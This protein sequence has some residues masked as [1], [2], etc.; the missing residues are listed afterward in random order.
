[1]EL[2]N[3]NLPV[4]SN[5]VGSVAH[6]D[7]MSQALDL[8]KTAGEKAHIGNHAHKI[9]KIFELAG[10]FERAFKYSSLYCKAEFQ[11][12]KDSV[13]MDRHFKDRKF[14]DYKYQVKK[15]YANLDQDDFEKDLKKLK[16]KFK[17]P[18][19]AYFLTKSKPF[20][21]GEF[22]W[23]TPRWVY[24][25]C[26]LVMGSIDLD[27]ATSVQAISM[28]N[29]A[30]KFFTKADNA[31][32]KTW[33]K[34]E[35]IFINPPY[36]LKKG[37][38]KNMFLD[39]NMP[40][41]KSGAKAFLTKLL[42]SQFRRAMLL[43]LEDSGTSY[44]QFLWELSNA[45]FIPSGRLHFV[46]KGQSKKDQTTRSTV[47]FGIGVDE[48]K[49]HLAFK[50][51]G[52]TRFNFKNP[53]EIISEIALRHIDDDIIDFHKKL[54][55]LPRSETRDKRAVK[56]DQY[57]QTLKGMEVWKSPVSFKDDGFLAQDTPKEKVFKKKR[58]A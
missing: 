40:T 8:A 27:P 17:I 58:K 50:D 32:E 11:I 47:I 41:E 23:Y 45:V 9:G 7:K 53:R 51:Y 10:H 24:E 22:E 25:R 44:G 19:R 36:T 37:A 13:G 15:A 1:M 56:E 38:E 52:L 42:N 16:S 12:S 43:V 5:P 34:V 30:D 31:L 54:K 28:G 48:I 29:K 55:A 20:G 33:P 18:T 4:G 6:F 26:R 39:K 2:E 35:N 46:Y 14:K 57:T 49:F 3:K 21:S